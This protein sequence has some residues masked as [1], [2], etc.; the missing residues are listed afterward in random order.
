MSDLYVNVEDKGDDHWSESSEEE[1]FEID[2]EEVENNDFFGG[3]T[4]I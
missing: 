1:N 4:G 2:D 3:I